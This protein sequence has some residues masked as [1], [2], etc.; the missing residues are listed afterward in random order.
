V[1][2]HSTEVVRKP[3]QT[4]KFSLFRF[5][6]PNLD[7]TEPFE[8]TARRPEAGTAG[9]PASRVAGTESAPR[10]RFGMEPDALN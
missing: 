9:T 3:R 2:S 6:A 5:V 1:Q 7:R 8:C 10:E 4:N